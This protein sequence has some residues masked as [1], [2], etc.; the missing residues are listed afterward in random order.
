MHL[1]SHVPLLA[2]RKGLLFWPSGRIR[3]GQSSRTG[4]AEMRKG[5]RCYY[6]VLTWDYVIVNLIW[7]KNQVHYG[8]QNPC[9]GITCCLLW[10][11]LRTRYESSEL[12]EAG[13]FFIFFTV[14]LDRE[15]KKRVTVKDLLQFAYVNVVGLS[16][17]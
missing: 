2:F 6:S 10:N 5:Q 11:D 1:I 3:A 4:T 14:S 7:R 12:T 13:V 8:E 17:E 16:P 9:F 15:Q